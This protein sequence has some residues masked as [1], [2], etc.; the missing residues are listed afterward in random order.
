MRCVEC[1]GERLHEKRV[2]HAGALSDGRTFVTPMMAL[3]CPECGMTYT[4]ASTVRS[5]EMLAAGAAEHPAG[6]RI[7]A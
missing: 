5:L 2:E 3:H 7:S 4:R 6:F 1:A